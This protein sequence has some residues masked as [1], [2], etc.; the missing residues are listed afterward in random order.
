MGSRYSVHIHVH[1]TGIMCQVVQSA[2][3]VCDLMKVVLTAKSLSILNPSG[4]STDYG[5]NYTAHLHVHV[6][7][8]NQQKNYQQSGQQSFSH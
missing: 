3:T 7:Y 5:V 1:V 4:F 6:A 8:H 2:C